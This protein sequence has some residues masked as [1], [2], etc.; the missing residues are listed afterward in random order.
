MQRHGLIALVYLATLLVALTG[1]AT[2]KSPTTQDG[3]RKVVFSLSGPTPGPNDIGVYVAQSKGYFADAGLDV[4]VQGLPDSLGKEAVVAQNQAQFGVSWQEDIT[5]A[6]EQGIPVVSIAATLAHNTSAFA[7]LASSG[8]TSPAQY[9]GHTYGGWGAPI[10]GAI[11]NSVVRQAGGEPSKVRNVN[12]GVGSTSTVLDALRQRQIDLGWIFYAEDG[13]AAKQ[14]G[15][16]LNYQFLKDMNPAL[17]WYTPVITTSEKLIAQDP[18]LVQAFVNAISRG[19]RDAIANPQEASDIFIKASPDADSATVRASLAWLADQFQADA[20]K[21]GWQKDEVWRGFSK[22]LEDA[23][24][25]KPGFD[26][27][28]AYTNQFIQNTP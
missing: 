14:Q 28:K 3:L 21:W 5:Q 13:L 19:Y 8:I 25:I 24:V 1:C 18:K 20:P 2:D 26:Y 10:E 16:D 9:T 11:L 22:W 4:Q 15:V 17:D 6:R 7:E 23:Q 27:A 12:I